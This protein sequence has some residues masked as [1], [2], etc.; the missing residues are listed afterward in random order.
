MEL[1][2]TSLWSRTSLRR[3]TYPSEVRST[4]SL[5]LDRRILRSAAWHLLGEAKQRGRQRMFRNGTSLLC[6]HVLLP[7]AALTASSPQCLQCWAATNFRP[8][9]LLTRQYEYAGSTLPAIC[10]LRSSHLRSCLSSDPKLSWPRHKKARRLVSR[11]P[12]VNSK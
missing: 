10:A 1:S 6:V 11:Q 9:A 5:A 7:I 2:R 4:A 12:T 8:S 3:V